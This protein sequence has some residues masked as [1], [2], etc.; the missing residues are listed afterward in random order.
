MLKRCALPAHYNNQL[1]SVVDAVVG[2]MG[3]CGRICHVRL[4]GYAISVM[5][6][7]KSPKRLQP[8]NSFREQ[9]LR[10]ASVVCSFQCQFS[11]SRH[12][13][14]AASKLQCAVWVMVPVP[15]NQIIV[16]GACLVLE[17]VFFFFFFFLFFLLYM[18][19]TDLCPPLK[20]E[21]QL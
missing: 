5:K 19:E 18:Q 6:K 2:F 17:R 1:T 9:S 11:Q 13:F 21:I 15:H 16:S 14:L 4:F 20:C 8:A 12:E 7:K 3:R 10:P